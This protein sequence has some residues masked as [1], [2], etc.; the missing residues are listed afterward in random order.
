MLP[1]RYH[2]STCRAPMNLEKTQVRVPRW[3]KQWWQLGDDALEYRCQACH[4]FH[5]M[6][7]TPRGW[8]LFGLVCLGMIAAW[9]A[10]LHRT[11]IMGAGLVSTAL[12][13]RH[14]VD[15]KPAHAA[16]HPS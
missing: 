1:G 10:D 15:L 3:H 12:L 2:C 8:L 4:Q 14:A 5:I 7:V 6:R 11:G 9:F 16:G 13:F